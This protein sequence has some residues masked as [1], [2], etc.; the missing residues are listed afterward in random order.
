MGVLSKFYLLNP[1]FTVSIALTANRVY[2][3]YMKFTILNA[4]QLMNRPDFRT[5]VTTC[6][7]GI[8]LD[9]YYC[10]GWERVDTFPKIT[11]WVLHLSE[12]SEWVT[13]LMLGDFVQQAMSYHKLTRADI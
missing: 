7:N 12:K 5:G 11:T 4:E 2:N 8:V 1:G 6:K 10:I 9:G 13:T 3:R